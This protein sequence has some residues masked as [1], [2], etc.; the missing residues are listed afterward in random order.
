MLQLKTIASTLFLLISITLNA[1][2]RNMSVF[3]EPSIEDF[4]VKKYTE[5]P[6]A[7]A[8]IL[9]EQGYYH[10]ELIEDR[11]IRIV[12]DVYQKIKVLDAKKFDGGEI[13]IHLL[14][15]SASQEKLINLTALT[16]N[17][18]IKTYVKQAE[19]YTL[20]G[21]NGYHTKRFAFP[22]IKDGSILEYKYSVE[23]PFFFDLKGWIFQ[24]NYPTV[25]SEFTTKIPGN[26]NYNKSLRGEYKLEVNDADIKKK[27]FHIEGYTS[28]D[29]EIATYAMKHIPAFKPEIYML[30][31][32][33]H[34]AA[35]NY[36][37]RDA[38][39]YSGS[40]NFYSKT[41]KN[42]D[43]EFKNDKDMG[44][45]LSYKGY[46]KKNLPEN[47]LA[48]ADPL[49]RAKAVYAF[50]QNHFTWN[51]AYRIFSE[52]R[53]KDAF[54]EKTGNIA[55]INI[56]LINALEAADLDAKIVLSSTRE[57]GIPTM[58]YPVLTDFNYV[59]AHLT[60]GQNKYILDA[61]NKFTPFEVVPYRALNVKGRVMDFK[62]GS[63]WQ[64]IEPYAKNIKY[65]NT[66]LTI[67][68]DG[69]LKGKLSDLYSGYIAVNER[70]KLDKSNNESYFK[71]KED[72]N[73]E[74]ENFTISNKNDLTQSLKTGYDITI[75]PD[76]VGDK[77]YVFPFLKSNLYLDENP[78]KEDTRKDPID[79]GYP[80]ANTYLV[81]IDLNDQYEVVEL[82]KSRVYKIPQN[83]G[84]C[85]IAYQTDDKKISVRLSTKL[86]LYRYSPESYSILKDF[87]TNVMTVQSKE[88]IVLK[89]K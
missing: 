33:N 20:K 25:Y 8:I 42:V 64:D 5:D 32:S 51:G 73:V 50:I 46:F 54:E 2:Q 71:N 53:V 18:G 16:N 48:I 89:K 55:E 13:E 39:D 80:F 36:E 27:C 85:S 47:V 4:A 56:A 86:N 49:E 82:P 62:K 23:S 44:R 10:F 24:N 38:L 29:C 81:S 43:T 87:L 69:E 74:I 70:E 77:I 58:S 79:I 14:T 11:Y 84:E 68:E 76:V 60:I 41:W 1:Q 45:Q 52:I 75:T 59:M 17:D 63:Y 83:G 66:R 31:E 40:K 88:P 15:N 26:F 9:Y 78:F 7:T 6:E 34:R 19:I 61:T 30:D 67:N 28:A 12:K 3:G 35:I 37:L 57:N 65:T 22:N 72:E 21:T